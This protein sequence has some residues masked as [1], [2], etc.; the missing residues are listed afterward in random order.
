[1]VDVTRDF[2]SGD[3]PD[4]GPE[5]AGGHACQGLY[6]H[7]LASVPRVAV[8]ATHYEVDFSEHYLAPYLA[9]LGFGFLG[10]NTRYRGRGAWFSLEP[11]LDDIAVGVRWLREAGAE[12]VVILGNSGGASLMAAYQAERAGSDDAGDLFVSLCAH[13]GRPDV[14][15]SWLDPSVTDESDPLS[16]DR[17][18]DMYD[19]GNGPPYT[20]EFVSR[21]RRAQRD[22]NE[23]IT[24]WARDELLRLHAAGAT[25]RV[26]SV[27]R[28]WAD[29][30]F[31][32]L[33]LEPTDRL[34][35]CYRGDPRRA[36]YGASGL[37]ASCTLRT[38]MSMWSLSQSRCRAELQLPRI[39][40][41]AL[42][43][44]STADQGVFPSDARAIHAGLAGP[45]RTLELVPGDHYLLDPA[46]ARLAVAGLIAGW[47]RTRAGS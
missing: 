7:P 40:Q 9:A 15:T 21:Y 42:V 41:P 34:P 10:W 6:Y 28:T 1:M 35:G 20:A 13:P 23:R 38:W 25:D 5:G 33:T 31:V 44:Q 2:V 17:E 39:G 16:L 8:I 37:A 11:A 14:L 32:D 3:P 29:L 36:N 19:P 46:G 26:F 4:L 45:D 30:R 12:T 47:I 27:P 18:L 43:V 22:R 24:A